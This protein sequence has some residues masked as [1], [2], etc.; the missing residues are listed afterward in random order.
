MAEVKSNKKSVAKRTKKDIQK[1]ENSIFVSNIELYSVNAQKLP[2]EHLQESSKLTRQNTI[3]VIEIK[4]N[5]MKIRLA[6]KMYFK[7]EGPFKLDIEVIGTYESTSDID[8]E[9]SKDTLEKLAG[10]LL[11]YA[12]FVIAFLTEKLT[13]IPIIVPPF[14]TDGEEEEM[15]TVISSF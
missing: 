3:D 4:N 13:V 9:I 5:T 15:G 1:D 8:K 12:S 11:S 7:P 14:K 2:I 6:E 10:P